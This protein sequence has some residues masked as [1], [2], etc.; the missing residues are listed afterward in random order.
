LGFRTAVNF[1]NPTD[2]TARVPYVNIHILN[3][4]SILGHV[5]AKNINVT[6]GNNT[7]VVV[8][9][10][11]DPLDLGGVEGAHVG[12]ELLSQYISGF[13]T[14]LTF[15]THNGSIPLQPAL[16]VALSRF[17]I[18]VPTP[19]FGSPKDGDGKDD[20]GKDGRSGPHFIKDA[21]FH[22]LS[23]TATFTLVSPLKHSTL[24]IEDINATALYNRT[25]PVGKI[26]YGYPFKVPPGESH[27]PRLPVD[28]SFDSVGY[29]KV[30]KALGGDLKLDAEAT[31]SVRLGEWRQEVWFVG[32]GIGANVRL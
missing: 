22:L 21:T 1:T 8:E 18:S 20:D 5:T 25:E 3:N 24:F 28:W 13:N 16:G 15:Q 11:W 29:E 14:T 32:G 6:T 17:N 26:V 30:R 19:K 9:T 31:V 4:G 27:T 2:Y 12:K 10:M 23:S 7:N